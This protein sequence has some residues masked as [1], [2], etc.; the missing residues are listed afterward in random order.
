MIIYLFT[1]TKHGKETLSMSMNLG[2]YYM[3][4]IYGCGI[5]QRNG[6]PGSYAAGNCDGDAPEL[7]K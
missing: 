7:A 3:S 5:C 6:P 1:Y 4:S 2:N